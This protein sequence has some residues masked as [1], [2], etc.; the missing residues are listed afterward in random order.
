MRTGS[1]L[2][3]IVRISPSD[4]SDEPVEPVEPVEHRTSTVTRPDLTD[5][6]PRT[7]ENHL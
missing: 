3:R 6:S 7:P 4:T 2:V 5:G 1:R